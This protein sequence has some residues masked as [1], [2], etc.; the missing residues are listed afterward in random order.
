MFLD[1]N[2][3]LIYGNLKR[4]QKGGKTLQKRCTLLL[5]RSRKRSLLNSAS[6]QYGN[7]SD[8]YKIRSDFYGKRSVTLTGGIFDPA[9][10]F[11]YEYRAGTFK[12]KAKN[13]KRR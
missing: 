6:I 5:R 10:S 12:E 7:I 2:E 3:G 4:I 1:L 8:E 11:Y 9:I 13:A